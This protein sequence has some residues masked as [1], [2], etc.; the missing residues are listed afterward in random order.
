MQSERTLIGQ[1]ITDNRIYHSLTITEDDIQQPDNKRIFRAITACINK[2][3]EADL[4]T[5]SDA[6]KNIPPG[7]LANITSSIASTANWKYYNDRVM[8]VSY[9]VKVKRLADRKSVV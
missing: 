4:L 2:G 6:D 8:A 3:I 9:K 7:E 5:V 1:I